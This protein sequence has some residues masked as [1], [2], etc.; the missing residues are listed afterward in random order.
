MRGPLHEAFAGPV[1]FDP[2]PS[3][4]IAKEPPP[5]VEETP[6]EQK[7]DGTNVHWIPG[8]W[9]WDE[10]RSDFIWVSGLWRDI[11]PGRQW[12]PG[13]WANDPGGFRWVA[14]AWVAATPPAQGT[15]QPAAQQA[16]QY[17]PA[18]PASIEAG[19]SSPAPVAGAVWTPGFWLWEG[20]RYVWRPGFWMAYQPDWIWVPAHYVWTP[21]GYLFV[22]GYW[23]RSLERRGTPF[24]PVYFAQPVYQQPQFVY[25]P[26]IT[27]LATAMV[28]SLFV[29]P[30]CQ[31]YYF[32]DYYATTYVSVGI[33]PAYSFH[34]GRSGYD[35]VFAH[36]A[37]E[38]L[39][40]DPNWLVQ[41]HEEYTF[42]RDHPEARPP[43]TYNAM[44]ELYNR[45]G[46]ATIVQQT[47]TNQSSVNITRNL[48]I[49]RPISQ[50]AA[51]PR[52]LGSTTAG[53]RV[54]EMRFTRINE[55]QRREIGHQAAELR[56]FHEQRVRQEMAAARPVR[57]EAVRQTDLRSRPS[58]SAQ[59]LDRPRQ[60]SATGSPVA[61]GAARTEA[62][63]PTNLPVTPRAAPD[64][65]YHSEPRP[66][67]PLEPHNNTSLLPHGQRRLEEFKTQQ[68]QQ[69][70]ALLKT[71]QEQLRLERAKLQSKYETSKAQRKSEASATERRDPPP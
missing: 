37:S 29:R 31:Q 35:P 48:V 6:P 57:N 14:G 50:I 34:Q 32:G 52:L 9:A 13:Y 22:N 10:S 38:N 64:P 18:P 11:P 41:V 30:A 27:L 62:R 53:G 3:P 60:L 46:G 43:Q 28:A 42:R 65:R 17:L 49:A 40:R 26:A 71:Q 68:A 45:P 70:Q 23:D 7:L 63:N 54:Q 5:P 44:R 19:P 20:G 12:V 58:A 33:Y 2:K 67:R 15:S 51:N 21:G 25:T 16:V 1:V 36:M 56:Q 55:E 66:D 59:P 24:A 8:Y 69:R 4:V 47:V 61:A 39:R